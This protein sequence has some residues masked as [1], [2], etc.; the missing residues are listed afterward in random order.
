MEIILDR[1]LYIY[2]IN[3]NVVKYINIWDIEDS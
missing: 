3:R 1:F 2:C